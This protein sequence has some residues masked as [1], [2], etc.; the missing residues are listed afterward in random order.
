V[1][2]GEVDGSAVDSGGLRQWKG[3]GRGAKYDGDPGGVLGGG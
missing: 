3:G 2:S 1:N